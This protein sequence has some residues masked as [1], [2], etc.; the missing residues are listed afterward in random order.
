MSEFVELS[1]KYSNIAFNDVPSKRKEIIYDQ[2][3]I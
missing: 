2:R 1:K 3:K